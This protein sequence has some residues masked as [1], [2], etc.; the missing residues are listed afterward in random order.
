MFSHSNYNNTELA[1]KFKDLGV[2]VAPI[3]YKEGH[4][5][6]VLNSGVTSSDVEL[7][8]ELAKSVTN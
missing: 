7:T 8:L 5:R 6:A 2:L 4:V 1:D 3:L